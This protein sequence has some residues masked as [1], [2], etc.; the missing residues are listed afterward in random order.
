MIIRSVTFA[1]LAC[2]LAT[3]LGGCAS[4]S[5][6]AT[7]T[8]T[9]SSDRAATASN[10]KDIVDN[11]PK[12]RWN[13]ALDKARDEFDGDVSKIELEPHDDGGLEYKIELMSKD[14][15]FAVQ[16]DADDL[17]TRSTKRDDLGDDAAKKRRKTFSTDDL[18][19]LDEAAKKARDEQ[20]G[21]ITKWKVEGSDDGAPHYE[22]DILP[23][24][25]SED[26]EIK[27]DA[28]D[29]SIRR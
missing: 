22:F 27:V 5:D 18:I 29:G 3:M 13:D 19:S 11:A 21:T 7:S 15:K 23:D 9:S 1:V 16:Y 4:G 8:A 26:V 6:T 28:T 17:S 14:T 10:S 2:S 24:G 25:A 20:S 12:K